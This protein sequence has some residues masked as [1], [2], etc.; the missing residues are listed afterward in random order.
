MCSGKS[1][2]GRKSFNWA[3]TPLIMIR[4]AVQKF[5]IGLHKMSQLLHKAVSHFSPPEQNRVRVVSKKAGLVLYFLKLK[6]D[7]VSTLVL[8]GEFD[9]LGGFIYTSV[10]LPACIIYLFCTYVAQTSVC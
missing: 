1:V 3:V 9:S 10:S 8:Q 7:E 5:V 4:T 2:L 6:R